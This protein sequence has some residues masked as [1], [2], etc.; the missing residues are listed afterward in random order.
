[1]VA[2]VGSCPSITDWSD[3]EDWKMA[4][5]VEGE[6]GWERD[7]GTIIKLSEKYL[8]MVDPAWSGVNILHEINKLFLVAD[9][10]S[11]A[12]NK[13]FPNKVR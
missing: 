6:Q 8:P 1:M 9:V 4:F 7:L 11:S 13:L 3:M 5:R 2:S 12:C 10:K